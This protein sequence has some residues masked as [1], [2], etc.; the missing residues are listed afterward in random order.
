MVAANAADLAADLLGA[1]SASTEA[2]YIQGPTHFASFMEEHNLDQKVLQQ[3]ARTSQLVMVSF[4]QWL[5]KRTT[6]DQKLVPPRFRPITS[7]Y[8]NSLVSQMVKWVEHRDPVISSTLRSMTSAALLKAYDK[9]DTI[10]RGPLDAYCV[11]PLSCEFLQQSLLELQTRYGND[12]AALALH[13]AVLIS[14]YCFGGRVYELLD[15]DRG[16]NPE[17]APESDRPF[18]NHAAH[19]EDILLRWSEEGRWFPMCDVD[20][21]PEGTPMVAQLMLKHTKNHPGGPEPVAVWANPKGP[22]PF[23]L[24]AA[25]RCYADLWKDVLRRGAKLFANADETIL[26]STRHTYTYTQ[27]LPTLI[28][29]N[30]INSL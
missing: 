14:E 18:I 17:I 5:R 3:G 10:I 23:C 1:R 6:W 19:C 9:T 24:C 22:D 8:I 16:E 15:R 20:Q 25:L 21:F 30:K 2:A 27:D 29:T 26:R 13:S 12:P 11:Y 28:F 7:D 4:I